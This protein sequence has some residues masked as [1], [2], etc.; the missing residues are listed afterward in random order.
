MAI[1]LV[2]PLVD[3]AKIYGRYH[4]LG[5][6][7]PP[8]GLAYIAAVLL[9]NGHEVKI[10]DANVLGL[11]DDAVVSQ[12]KS[13]DPD[14]IGLTATTLSHFSATE[15]ALAFKESG[16]GCP[17]VLGGP[18][19]LG[20]EHE[21]LREPCFDYAISGEGEQ[22]MLE[23]ANA[24]LKHAPVEAIKGLVHRNGSTITYNGDRGPIPDL[25]QLPF[26]ARHLLPD[27]NLYRPKAI[28]YKR[29]PSTHLFTSRGCPYKCI[30]CRTAFGRDVRFHNYQYTIAEIQ[31]LISDF[32]IKEFIINDDTFILDR[33][34]VLAFCQSIKEMNIDITWSCN[35]RANLVDRELLIKMK[36]AGCWEVAIGL[37]S[38]NQQILNSL[39]KGITLEQ[40]RKAC[41][42]AYE[43]GLYVR[44]SFILGSPGETHETIEQTIDFAKSLPVHYPTFSLMTPFPGTEIWERA[45][46]W[47]VFDRQNLS[48]LSL[49][50]T[51]SF[52]PH[53]LSA[54][55]L[56]QCIKLAYKRTYFRP[57]M[58]ARHL[59][60]I[61]SFSDIH[62]LL[63]GAVAL[64]Q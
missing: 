47:G 56:E 30:F 62:K 63:R 53:G 5:G 37:E 25:D 8:L 36:E 12:V 11:S 42:L 28:S 48:K 59:S 33:T 46:E 3:K 44:P 10:I 16:I 20:M 45:D 50:T 6:A 23:L 51:A 2:N 21:S 60:K 35:I 32:G 57:S 64:W 27:L 49:S 52:V 1:V 22:T 29:L 4:K 26:P 24:V 38:G 13:L 58:V 40:G 39:K 61:R 7:L 15:L 55:Y 18:H 54:A 17:I 9:K 34:R 31:H 41:Q 14:M 19:V 43:A